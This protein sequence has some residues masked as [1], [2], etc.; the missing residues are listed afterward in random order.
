MKI[1]LAL[2]LLAVSGFSQFTPVTAARIQRGV[3]TPGSSQCA[4][5]ADVGK[6]YVNRT[7]AAA[8][9]SLYLCANT[10]ASTY[11]WE[12]AGSGGGGSGN[13]VGPS[14]ATDGCVPL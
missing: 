1:L 5:A 13:V 14:S 7:A 12:L 6:V 8:A 4:H 9:S 10:A 11:A 3:G 2:M